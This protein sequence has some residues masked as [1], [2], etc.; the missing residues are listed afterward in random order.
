VNSVLDLTHFINKDLM[1]TLMKTSVLVG[2][3]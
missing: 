1:K 3:H 2:W